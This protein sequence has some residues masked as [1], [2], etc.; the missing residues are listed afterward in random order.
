MKKHKFKVGDLVR[1][2]EYP[3]LGVG[4]VLDTIGGQGN[5]V[6]VLW[7]D[8]SISWVGCNHLHFAETPIQRM[9]RKWNED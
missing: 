7:L 2:K 5:Y 8:G 3:E 6:D 1:I 4:K 9:K